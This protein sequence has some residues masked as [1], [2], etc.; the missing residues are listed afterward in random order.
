[1]PVTRGRLLVASYR[2]LPDRSVG[3]LRW[4]GL[5]KYLARAGWEVHVLTAARQEPGPSPEYRVHQCGRWPTL[6]DFYRW[7]ASS[8]RRDAHVS[9]AAPPGPESLPQLVRREAASLMSFPDESRG[10]ML[11]AALRARRLVSQL[12]PSM[13]ISSGPPH[14]AHLV[15]A[16]GVAGTRIPF[17]VDLR[18]PWSN[19]S[20]AWQNHPV[21]G[22]RIAR[23]LVRRLETL[24]LHR[25]SAV[26]A[27]TTALR[28][29]LRVRYPD[30]PVHWLPNGVDPE[31]LVAPAYERPFPGLAIAHVGT[32]YGGRDPRPLL[33]AFRL[34][35]DRHPDLGHDGSR[36]RLAGNIEADHAAHLAECVSR[37]GLNG[38]V[39]VMGVV[40]P[41]EALAVLRRSSVVVVLAQHQELQVPGKL[42]EAVYL[43]RPTLVVAEPGSA[44]A[45]EAERLG[46]RWVEPDDV[47]GVAAAL[48][49]LSRQPAL[50]AE[51]APDR[52]L[53]YESLSREM[54]QILT[55]LAPRR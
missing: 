19:Q 13:V 1:M 52:R 48:E 20:S 7:L 5:T 38:F 32:L 12:R 4:G 3:G 54:D 17:V 21:Y 45:Q 53:D 34:M 31:R 10:W 18:D 14:S 24:A 27:N 2:F 37:H 43:R 41:A 47:A 55:N 11:R 33:E 40:P 23:R 29:A 35:L 39:E 8:E 9:A 49:A 15:A 44:S 22:R 51:P 28:E 50:P 25:A 46:I 30:L 6:N 42:Y 16:L 36:I 26:I